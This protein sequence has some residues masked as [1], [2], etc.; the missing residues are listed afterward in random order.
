MKKLAILLLVV[1][2]VVMLAAPVSAEAPHKA[3]TDGNAVT[4]TIGG[5]VDEEVTLQIKESGG[6]KVVHIDQVT[7]DSDGAVFQMEL[8]VGE[9]TYRAY[10]DDINEYVEGKFTV[11]EAIEPPTS[12]PEDDPTD[13]SDDPTDPSDDPTDPSNDPT[14]PSND[15]TDPS[16]DP[17]DPSNDPTD[18]S[19]DPTDPSNDPTDPSNDPTDPSDDPTGDTDATGDADSTDGTTA[20]SDNEPDGEGP[21]T[22]DRGLI[23]PL[24]LMLVS[25]SLL[26]VLLILKPKAG[27][28]YAQK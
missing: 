8:A 28:K 11:E 24:V 25:G 9:Y 6:N 17:T 2:F 12:E 18:P 26:A 4:I 21:E 19:N 23:G 14:D 7:A 5:S 3:E 10:L 13:P 22:G 1:S 16:N 15:P 20:P 27:G